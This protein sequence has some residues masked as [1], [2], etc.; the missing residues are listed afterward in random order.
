MN[1]D[2]RNKNCDTL[3]KQRI[4]T[5]SSDSDDDDDD[6]NEVNLNYTKRDSCK[7]QEKYVKI[8]KSS[9]KHVI[10]SRSSCWEI[11]ELSIQRQK[12]E[13]QLSHCQME[14]SVNMDRHAVLQMKFDRME[15]TMSAFLFFLDCLE[16]EEKASFRLC[17]QLNG[18][19]V[20]EN[21]VV[22]TENLSELVKNLCS[23]K[24]S[25]TYVVKENLRKVLDVNQDLENLMADYNDKKLKFTT[26]SQNYKLL[27]Q[28][29]SLSISQLEK[30]QTQF[31]TIL[32]DFQHSRCL[33]D[34]ELP[35]A[36]AHRLEILLNSFAEL[37]SDLQKIVSDRADLSSLL[38]HLETCLRNCNDL[39]TIKEDEAALVGGAIICSNCSR[40]T[41]IARD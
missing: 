31:D 34:Q 18:L 38:K 21:S 41:A 19:I 1:K 4:A 17:Q 39:M 37:H 32:L 33:L 22:I 25:N 20:R 13:M 6:N 15:N 2:K 14:E 11:D 5:Y 27:L 30:L 28:S 29:A 10:V 3:L 23:K 36:I 40:P 8:K 16:L 24:I 7:C 9:M 35:T 26:A 12:L